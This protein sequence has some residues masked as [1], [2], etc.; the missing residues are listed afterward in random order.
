MRVGV[1]EAEP[2]LPEPPGEFIVGG[3]DGVFWFGLPDDGDPDEP[4]GEGEPELGEPEL[5]DP[6]EGDPELGE[7]ELGDPDP[8]EPDAEVGTGGGGGLGGMFWKSS[9]AMSRPRAAIVT[10]M[11]Q[12][13][14]TVDH[15]AR[16]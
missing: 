2:E 10:M 4:D 14:P 3:V 1:G 15:P 5:G 8:P 11:S 12:E 6:D 13:M 7:P 16:S 9:T